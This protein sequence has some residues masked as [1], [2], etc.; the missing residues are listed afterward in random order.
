MDLLYNVVECLG[1]L[2]Q[3]GFQR[4][5]LFQENIVDSVFDHLMSQ[6]NSPSADRQA[7][8]DL[9]TMAM[10]LISRMIP[11]DDEMENSDRVADVSIINVADQARMYCSPTERSQYSGASYLRS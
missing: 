3:L 11:T 4:D 5:K 10:W 2:N 1:N 9:A 7:I 8:E 6:L